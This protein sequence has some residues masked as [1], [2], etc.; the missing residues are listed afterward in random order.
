MGVP[1]RVLVHGCALL[2]LTG[3]AH[4]GL[5]R[6]NRLKQLNPRTSTAGGM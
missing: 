1:V 6:P 4:L 3:C 5:L 2:T